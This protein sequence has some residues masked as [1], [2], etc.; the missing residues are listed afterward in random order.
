MNVRC[1]APATAQVRAGRRD[2]HDPRPMLLDVVEH[3]LLDAQAIPHV[4]QRGVD[5]GHAEPAADRQ[6]TRGRTDNL[7]PTH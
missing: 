2:V 3:D 4:H 5:Q 7:S 1:C 6:G